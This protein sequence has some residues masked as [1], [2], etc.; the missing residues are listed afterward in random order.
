MMQEL[1]RTKNENTDLEK[2]RDKCKADLHASNER[3]V[4]LAVEIDDQNEKQDLILKDEMKVQ[5]CVLQ[6]NNEHQ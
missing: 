2:E 3:S 6:L 1:L 4:A 5:I